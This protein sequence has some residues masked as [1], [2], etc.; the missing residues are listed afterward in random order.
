MRS[1][2]AAA[3]VVELELE[4][5]VNCRRFPTAASAGFCRMDRGPSSAEGKTRQPLSLLSLVLRSER[6]RVCVRESRCIVPRPGKPVEP[7]GCGGL[8]LDWWVLVWGT[9]DWGKC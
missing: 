8:D 4:V 6:E 3:G 7:F 5:V 9:L 2:G 1:T